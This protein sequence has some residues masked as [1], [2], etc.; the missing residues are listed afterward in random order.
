MSLNKFSILILSINS[1]VINWS[2]GIHRYIL[3]FVSRSPLT[4]FFS[5]W[6][7]GN[8]RDRTFYRKFITLSQFKDEICV[9]FSSIFSHFCVMLC[10]LDRWVHWLFVDLFF[11]ILFLSLFYYNR[12]FGTN[13]IF[14]NV[15]RLFFTLRLY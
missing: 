11:F 12:V 7:I 9:N 2:R 13:A 5:L 3:V 6:H 14:R 1:W 15:G 8:S 10:L 4:V